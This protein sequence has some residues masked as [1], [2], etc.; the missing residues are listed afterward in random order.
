MFGVRVVWIM[1]V[2]I[3]QDVWVRI[4]MVRGFWGAGVRRYRLD[5]SPT[6]FFL[7]ILL[8]N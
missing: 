1:P 8:I 3:G 7:T 5:Q 4:F 2:L 6:V